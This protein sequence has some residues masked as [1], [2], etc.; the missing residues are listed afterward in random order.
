MLR[1]VSS[2]WGSQVDASFVVCATL[3]FADYTVITYGTEDTLT[4]LHRA[5]VIGNLTSLLPR[6]FVVALASEPVDA[7]NP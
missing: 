2:E 3:R 7:L 4:I 5:D 6:S 1:F